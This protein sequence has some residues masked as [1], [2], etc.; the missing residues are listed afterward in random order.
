MPYFRLRHGWLT[1]AL[2]F[3]CTDEAP[4]SAP[5]GQDLFDASAPGP[6][7][8]MV[9]D[10]LPLP[11]GCV[12]DWKTPPASLSCTGLYSS[13]IHKQVHPEV[14]E[15]MP[16]DQL[17]TDDAEKRRWIWLPPGS[18]IDTSDLNEWTFP[19][20]TKTWKEFKRDGK[21]IETRLFHK[22]KQD[23][24]ERWIWASYLWN[25]DETQADFT[26]GGLDVPALTGAPHYI[27]K[28]EECTT[29][30]NGR[31]DRLL[32]FE[33]ALLG[34]PGAQGVS[35][36]SLIADKR[37]SHPPSRSDYS[38]PDDGTGL[39][40][41]VVS[42]LHVNCGVSCHNDNARSKAA[43]SGQFLRI[44]AR[45]LE[46]LTPVTEWNTLQTTIHRTAVTTFVG[47]V[48]IVPG[49]P[50]R[51]LLLRLASLRGSADQMPPLGT[52]VV[53]QAPLDRLRT[54]IVRLGDGGL[55]APPLMD[56]GV[57]S[58]EQPDAG[59]SNISDDAT[60]ADAEMIDAESS[61]VPDASMADAAPI[62]AAD[63]GVSVRFDASAPELPDTDVPEAAI[64]GV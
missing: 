45:K 29:C 25:A 15:F 32:G 14:R 16:A 39:A 7:V 30:H 1:L 17:W 64:P 8:G 33:A 12:E 56:A 22:V 31:T 60:V 53:D 59:A 6:G 49:A 42:W 48:R 44:D 3:G 11:A 34:L 51:S 40:A 4:R 19:V 20:G 47:S 24:G 52:R 58:L 21:R 57:P 41:P 9:S 61:P 26:W 23:D 5:M 18:V 27:P 46:A 13:P 28:S 50:E 43:A 37:L 63:T 55:G 54:W 10:R 2:I 36:S 38:I 35:L 62:E